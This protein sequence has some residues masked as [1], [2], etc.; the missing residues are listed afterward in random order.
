MKI[1][2]LGTGAADWKPEDAIPDT[3][4]FRRLSSMLID[5]ELLIDAGP[6]VLESAATFGIDI[7]KIRYIIQTHSHSD[8]L[9]MPTM[10]YFLSKGAQWIRLNAGESCIAGKYTI[11]ALTANHGTCPDT[12]HYLIDDG[13]KR[14]FYGMDGAWLMHDEVLAIR[15]KHV[16]LAI[17]DGTLGDQEGDWRIFSHNNLRM[18]EEMQKT[19]TPYV[20]RFM[21]NH[22]ARFLHGDHHSVVKRME[23]SGI[24]VAHDNLSMDV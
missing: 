8:H 19:L 1:H 2:F 13:E 11:D 10:E 12:V 22:M 23:P 24:L 15:E 7:S 14:L 20:D 5:G 6:C 21:I 16:D 17:L 18:V 4:L 9:H 3:N